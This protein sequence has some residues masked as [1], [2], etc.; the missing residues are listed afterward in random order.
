MADDPAKPPAKEEV[1]RGLRFLHT[2]AMQSKLDLVDALGRLNALTEELVAAGVV[3]RD[4]LDLRLLT[5]RSQE[6]S[7]MLKQGHLQVEV[8]PPRDKYAVTELPQID[9]AARLHLC[10]ARCCSFTF[11]LSFQDLDE[12]VVRWEYGRPYRI[13]K[14]PDGMCVHND[15]GC[16]CSV[17]AQR[18]YVCRTYDCRQDP[19][20]WVDFEARIPAPMPGEKS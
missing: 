5:A 7:R 9:C 6:D 14:R 18:P 1:E 8:G 16:A 3:Q 19:R 15:G 13:R 17:Y 20:V 11:S 12:G 2:F 10:K 4:A